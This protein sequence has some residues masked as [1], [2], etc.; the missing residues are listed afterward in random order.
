MSC[1]NVKALHLL[2]LV[3]YSLERHGLISIGNPIMGLTLPSDRLRFIIRIPIPVR[4]RLIVNRDP[5][6]T[7]VY[8]KM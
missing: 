5:R 1:T 4:R 6:K 2:D 7:H 8:L 3:L